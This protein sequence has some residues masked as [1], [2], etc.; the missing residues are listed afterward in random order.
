MSTA[1]EAVRTE[2]WR[3][4]G[5]IWEPEALAITDHLDQGS[6]VIVEGKNGIGKTRLLIPQIQTQVS[7]RG[8]NILIVDLR[9]G[10]SGFQMPK[11]GVFIGD[12]AGALAM[13]GSRGYGS[14]SDLAGLLRD[15]ENSSSLPVLINSGGTERYRYRTRRAITMSSL[16]TSLRFEI[17]RLEPKQIPIGLAGEFLS[18]E[19]A[20]NDL[21]DFAGQPEAAPLLYPRMFGV[22]TGQVEEFGPSEPINDLQG[23][24]N[25]LS[26]RNNFEQ[27]IILCGLERAQLRS[28][29]TSLGTGD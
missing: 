18:A 17:V 21:I 10:C 15:L 25:F 11:G 28:I 19:G 6:G 27:C 3:K 26:E 22:V 7:T 12:E 16:A 24:K 20:G 13:R 1:R 9:N 8:K 2:F 23:L 14:L 4:A 5:R 29:T